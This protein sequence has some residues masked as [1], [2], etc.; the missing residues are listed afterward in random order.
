[1]EGTEDSED[2]E[3]EEAAE[4]L[5]EQP[6]P[7]E[8]TT[9]TNS[10]KELR[11]NT[12]QDANSIQVTNQVV[13]EVKTE[14]NKNAN[15]W[16]LEIC[17]DAEKNGHVNGDGED[18]R[19]IENIVEDQYLEEN[20][21]RSAFS[22]GVYSPPREGDNYSVCN[23]RNF[24]NECNAC[25]FCEDVCFSALCKKCELKRKELYVK[26]KAY[27]KHNLRRCHNE[28]RRVIAL[29]RKAR[30]SI[31][32][33]RGKRR[34][35]KR[36]DDMQSDW[37][38]RSEEVEATVKVNKIADVSQNKCNSQNAMCKTANRDDSPE[39]VNHGNNQDTYEM[40]EILHNDR[41]KDYRDYARYK[42]CYTN[43]EIRRHCKEND[44]WLVANGYVYDVTTTLSRHP[45]GINCI[46]KKGGDDA[47]VD[48]AFHSTY[49]QKNFWEP[50]K[51]GRV[52]TCKKEMHKEN[53]NE[54]ISSEKRSRCIQM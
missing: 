44:C 46:L 10:E 21:N 54:N 17:S 52:I 27:K 22:R 5:K 7:E 24:P 34:D 25:N 11:E 15:Q 6:H 42:G 14:I 20:S 33:T 48:Y 29:S 50:L 19:M 28:I 35:N 16:T 31:L 9:R 39:K 43:C 51:I 49:A 47:T 53:K 38:E 37:G 36:G 8:A 30:E 41:R 40:E 18:E 12:M 32:F 1:M 23:V 13:R 3:G 26:Y 4:V 45:G 2:E